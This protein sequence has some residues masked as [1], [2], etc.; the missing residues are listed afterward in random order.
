MDREAEMIERYSDLA[1]AREAFND[2]RRRGY[3]VALDTPTLTVIVG[4]LLKPKDN[5]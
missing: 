2:W 5:E 1:T 3:R 4:Q